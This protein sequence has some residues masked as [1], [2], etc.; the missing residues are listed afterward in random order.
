MVLHTGTILRA[1]T[2]DHDDRMLLHIVTC[3]RISFK[4]SC[5]LVMPKTYPLQE[6][7]L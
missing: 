1:S 4:P 6:C 5:L 7:M 3:Q 2:S